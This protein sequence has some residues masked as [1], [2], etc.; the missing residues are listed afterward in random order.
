MADLK[1][2]PATPAEMPVAASLAGETANGFF[3]LVGQTFGTKLFSFATQIAL[4]RLLEPHDFGLV[5]LAYTAVSFAGIIRWTGLQQILVQRHERFRRWV[6]PAF[7]LELAISLAATLLLVIASPI[8]AA[9]FRSPSLIGLILV[10]ASAA[11]LS[12]W[13]VIPTARL[14]IDMRFRAM[15]L[16]NVVYSAVVMLLSIFLAWRG[17]G[18]YSFVIP[19]PIAGAVR[20]A[21]LW[22]LARPQIKLKPQLRRWRFL[23]DDSISMLAIGFLNSVMFQA[24]C[25]VLGIMRS[26]TDVGEFFLALNLSTQISQL[27]SQ[28]LGSVL[29]PVLAKM[30]RQADRGTAAL[31]GASRLLSFS[32]TPL[33]LLLAA[34][35]KPIVEVLYGTKWLPAVPMLQIMAIVAAVNVPSGPAETA[36]QAQGRF[37]KLFRWT[38]VQAPLFVVLIVIGSWLDGPIGVTFM[39][40]VFA[41]AASPITIILALGKQC[42]KR[43]ILDIY[44]GPLAA[45]ALALAVPTAAAALWPN[46]TTNRISWLGVATLTMAAVYLLSSL[47]FCRPELE[48]LLAYVR[49]TLAAVGVGRRR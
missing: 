10:I 42:Q 46:L 39:W 17:F 7:W 34:A 48:L 16:I 29:L 2:N 12:P 21:W 20:A 24:G 43:T 26:K 6:N 18:A 41:L 8:A 1:S 11:P 3:W 37:S 44:A 14:T 32:S 9:V 45:G 25:L 40:L 49:S 38:A 47:L 5:A 13:F 15:A 27:L 30:Q 33:C 31:I 23:L 28:N 35:A 4:A 36:L 22:G 19:L